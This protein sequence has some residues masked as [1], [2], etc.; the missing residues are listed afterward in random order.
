M[1]SLA[2]LLLHGFEQ[3]LFSSSTI[4][5]LPGRFGLLFNG[6]EKALTWCQNGC[7]QDCQRPRCQRRLH[8]ISQAALAIKN[9]QKSM[10]DSLEIL[11]Q[12]LC[13]TWNSYSL[14]SLVQVS[15]SKFLSRKKNASSQSVH[16]EMV[17]QNNWLSTGS[18]VTSPSRWKLKSNR[19]SG[20]KAESDSE[21]KL[22]TLRSFAILPL[23][24]RGAK[25]QSFL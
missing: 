4:P 19:F 21:K 18:H 24:G 6:Q 1:L 5:L 22:V 25:L 13:K 14:E 17:W 3:R 10:Y 12:E 2:W 9:F 20:K 16:C 11:M 15:V 8:N 23:R 7:Y